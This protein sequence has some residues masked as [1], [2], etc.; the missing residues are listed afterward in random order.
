M[1]ATLAVS[2][3]RSLREVRVPLAGLTVV[4]GPN[5]SGK[6]SL[7]RAIRLLADVGSGRLIGSLAREGG[8]G[9]A[10]WAGPAQL[11]AAR[12][13]GVTQ[14]ILRKGPISLQVGFGSDDFGYLM[15]LGLPAQSSGA[16]GSLFLRD[17]EI[18]REVVFS[19]PAMRPAGVLARRSWGTVEVSDS[20]FDG[21]T[22]W[23]VLDRRLP[24]Y[25][26]M[27]TEYADP[28]R[29]AELL[30]VREQL[31]SWRF[32]DSFRADADA[33]ARRPAVGTRTPVL[34]DDGRDLA[35]AL[36]TIAEDGQRRLDATI[37]DAFE[38]TR[39]EVVAVDG[40]FDVAVHQ[41]GMLRAL[42]A[43][44]LSDGTLRYLLWVAALLSPQPPPLL[45]VN[46]P[47]ASL[48]PSL[49]PALARLITDAATRSQVIVVTHSVAMVQALAAQPVPDWD[50]TCPLLL[51][52]ERDSG[53]TVVG[54]LGALSTPQWHW[55]SRRSG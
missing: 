9:S 43:A 50:G 33:P 39:V 13:S 38:G 52:L 49:L 54:G 8:L 34:A 12:Q 10:L 18:K 35:A 53:E 27:L 3:Y 36:Q 37:A 30:V 1:L 42:R 41:P 24:P 40:W 20:D 7:Y 6:S 29:A 21:R 44:E 23:Q 15:D 32:Y 47:E 16:Q 48:H 5:G 11:R 26:S 4:T 17:P 19:G 45:V 22:T 2:G 46:E 31:R 51:P 55:G 25:R 14:G 28:D